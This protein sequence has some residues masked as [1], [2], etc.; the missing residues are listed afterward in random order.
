VEERV[1]EPQQRKRILADAILTA[2]NNPIRHLRRQ[3][4]ELL[5][6]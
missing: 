1:L 2:D 4:L 3:D 6:S 5:L